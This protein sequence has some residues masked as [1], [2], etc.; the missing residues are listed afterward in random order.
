MED[1][2]ALG[3]WLFLGMIIAASIVSEAIKERD[4]QREKQATLRALLEKEGSSAT[5]VLA[6]MR[7]RDAA[8]VAE[9]ARVRAESRAARKR[10]TKRLAV[11]LG[12]F[13]IVLGIYAF[14]AVHQ[15]LMHGEGSIVFP[16]VALL[17]IWAAGLTI[18]WLMWRSGKQTHD[19]HPDA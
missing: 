18:A 7:E 2:G 6:Y 15:G 3:F 11:P 14:L 10:L 5:E 13:T 12:I 9:A 8:A 1:L 16:L 17:G 4:R 19:V